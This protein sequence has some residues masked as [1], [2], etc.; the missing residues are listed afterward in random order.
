[1]KEYKEYNILLE[2]SNSQWS[3]YSDES[4]SFCLPKLEDYYDFNQAKEDQEYTAHCIEKIVFK[5]TNKK[6][7]ELPRKYKHI[8][9]DFLSKQDNKITI[10][11]TNKKIPRNFNFDNFDIQSPFIIYFKKSDIFKI[12]QHN[13][14]VPQYSGEDIV[15]EKYV[16]VSSI[17]EESKFKKKKESLENYLEKDSLTFVKSQ[18]NFKGTAL[19]IRMGEL[20]SGKRLPFDSYQLLAASNFKQIDNFYLE[21]NKTARL[22]VVEKDKFSIDINQYATKK[23]SHKNLIDYILQKQK[24]Q[25]K[26]ITPQHK[27]WTQATDGRMVVGLGGASVYE[28]SM[29]LHHIYGI[30]YIPASSIKGVVR[31]WII[32]EV[33]YPSLLDRDETFNQLES[34]E[35]NKRLEK[36]AMQDNIFAAIFGTDDKALDSKAHKGN[37]VFF[38]AFPA[39]EPTIE[40]DIMTP[41]YSDYYGDID[42]KKHKAPV[43]T[44]SPI[45]IPFLTVAKG[46]KFQFIIG[47]KGNEGL[48]NQPFQDK[49]IIDWLKQA[50]SEHG[51]GAKTAVGYGYMTT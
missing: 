29:T 16:L 10:Q 37:I 43:D 13:L 8:I 18:V 3:I 41:H 34:K 46:T 15:G 50:L 42:N 28:T 30:P 11:S 36:V 25:A 39:S 38:D 19:D 7:I 49:T 21:L 47:E 20:L 27:C 32:Q 2:Y 31:S 48:L 33:I 44:E 35:Q 51:I 6:G 23:L 5:I 40:T 22:G 45:P 24:K 26:L 1:M 17:I 9:I 4:L 14:D 12:N